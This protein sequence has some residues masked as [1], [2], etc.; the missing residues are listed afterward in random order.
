M[1]PRA[2]L[3]RRLSSKKAQFLDRPAI[4]VENRA[5]LRTNAPFLHSP[6]ALIRKSSDI[7]VRR[8]DP[9]D[10]GEFIALRASD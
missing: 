2:Q 4:S 10:G 6:R 9:T 3:H 7:T 1:P 5:V 8:D